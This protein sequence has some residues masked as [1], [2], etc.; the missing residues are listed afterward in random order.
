MSETPT[1]PPSSISEFPPHSLPDDESQS[2]LT[3]PGAICTRTTPLSTH[4]EVAMAA[5]NLETLFDRSWVGS[6]GS[7][8]RSRLVRRSEKCYLLHDQFC[9]F[10]SLEGGAY[11]SFVYEVPESRVEEIRGLFM[12]AD[13]YIDTDQPELGTEW[14]YLKTHVIP[15]LREMGRQS[16]FKWLDG[17]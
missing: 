11:R 10:D 17:V 13:E 3:M 12:K 9:G 16:K 14:S 1:P 2:T 4:P 8:G 6:Y 5:M 7:T 15:T